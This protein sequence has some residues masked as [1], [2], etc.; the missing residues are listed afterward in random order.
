MVYMPLVE[1]LYYSEFCKYIVFLLFHSM[2]YLD[3]R[4]NDFQSIID[5]YA[6]PTQPV[7]LLIDNL[8]LYHGNKGHH[9]LF[10]VLGP[11]MWNLTVRG[12]LVPQLPDIAHLFKS[13]ETVEEAQKPMK[14]VKAE[15][16]FIGKNKT[17]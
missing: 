6:P 12:L 10:K 15:D 1:S 11:K 8:N 9:R 3:R 2:T 7:I 17:G 5:D 14:D 16:L 4:L 13:Q